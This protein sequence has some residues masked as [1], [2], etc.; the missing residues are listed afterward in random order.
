MKIMIISRCGNSGNL[1][2]FFLKLLDAGFLSSAGF[3]SAVCRA[4]SPVKRGP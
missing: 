3:G 4:D 2:D 1:E